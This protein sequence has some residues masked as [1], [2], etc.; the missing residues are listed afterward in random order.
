MQ[1]METAQ[2]GKAHDGEMAGL[3]E[4]A[5]L[6]V[7]SLRRLV[8]GQGSCPLVAR[9]F[10]AVCR[11]DAAEVFAAFG[12]F[13]CMLAY[14]RLRR[15]SVGLPGESRLTPD[16]RQIVDM[17]A[18]AQSENDLLFDVYVRRFARAEVHHE[19]KLAAGAMASAFAAHGLRLR[20]SRPALTLIRGDGASSGGDVGPDAVRPAFR[21]PPAVLTA[22]HP[23]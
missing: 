19:V 12:V 20:R 15:L 1:E 18:V 5:R 4:G 23:V 10:A 9:E 7:W 22:L 2:D 21:R 6:L 16:E 11:N 17:V 14:A 3:S 13:L 8:A